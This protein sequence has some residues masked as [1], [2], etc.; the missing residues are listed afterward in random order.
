MSRHPAIVIALALVAVAVAAGT[1]AAAARPVVPRAVQLRIA[2]RAPVLAYVPTR[3]ALGFRYTGWLKTPATVRIR[4]A[5][6]A[7][8]QIRFVA[9]RLRGS[10]RAGDGEELPAR[11]QQ[12][13]LGAHRS[14]AAGVALCQGPQGRLIRLVASSPQ[15]STK[16]ADVGLGRVVA[17]GKRIIV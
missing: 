10:C 5:N 12:G 13:L 6:R 1:A 2:V 7:G 4:F 9:V 16:F 15:P 3:M 14:G 8:W 17:S 11:R